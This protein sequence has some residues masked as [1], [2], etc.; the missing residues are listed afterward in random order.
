MNLKQ[1]LGRWL[2]IPKAVYISVLIAALVI[3]GLWLYRLNEPEILDPRIEVRTPDY[4]FEGVTMTNIAPSGIPLY[5]IDAPKMAHFSDDDSAELESP[6]MQIF[7][8]SA[9]PLTV[10]SQQAWIASGRSEILLRGEVT[11]LRP[12]LD[13]RSTLT[14]ETKNLRVF[15]KQQTATTEESVL[16]FS[17][18]YRL[19]GEGGSIDLEKGYLR[20][21]HRARGLYAP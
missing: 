2:Q 17:E 9:P 12:E 20:I 11:I 21:H 5:R 19:Y 3:A 1:L 14:I 10:R 18:D 7:R 8:D 4:T 13:S 15:P 16:A 6:I